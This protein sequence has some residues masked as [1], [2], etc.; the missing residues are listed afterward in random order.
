MSTVTI[1]PL[2]A[3]LIDKSRATTNINSDSVNVFDVATTMSETYGSDPVVSTYPGKWLLFYPPSS[4]SFGDAANE[5]IASAT[6][7]VKLSTEFYATDTSSSVDE[8][9]YYS[10]VRYVELDSN[11]SQYNSVTWNKKPS[12]Q[13]GGTLQ[14]FVTLQ[15]SLASGATE[16][17]TNLNL[18]TGS[19]TSW[20][21]L[22]FLKKEIAYVYTAGPT[23]NSR[24]IINICGTGDNQKFYITVQTEGDLFSL[25]ESS[26]NP[27]EVDPSEANTFAW[28]FQKSPTKNGLVEQ[29]IVTD[30]VFYWESLADGMEHQ[31]PV[32]VDATSITIPADTFPTTG[33]QWHVEARNGDLRTWETED[34]IV[35][36]GDRITKAIL[37]SPTNGV[38]CNEKQPLLLG[39]DTTNA[40][41][42]SPS[43]FGIEWKVAGDDE[44]NTFPSIGLNDVSA[45][46]N[47]Y[48]YAVPENTFPNG[49]ITWRIRAYNQD[50]I[51]GPWS[52]EGYFTTI[53]YP[54]T[55][56]AISPQSNA[57]RDEK[58]PILFEWSA[59][60]FP[61]DFTASKWELQWKTEGSEWANLVTLTQD[62]RSYTAPADTFP[63]DVITWRVRGYNG[64][65]VPGDWSDEASFTTIDPIPSATIIA[66]K[67]GVWID[68]KESC[69]FQWAVTTP[70]AD[71]DTAISELQ[72]KTELEG[73]EWAAFAT[74][75]NGERSYSVPANALPNDNLVWRVRGINQDNVPG[76][77]AEEGHFT[78]ID[79]P[80]TCHDLTPSNSAYC[81]S[82]K[83]IVLTWRTD[84]TASLFTPS[85]FDLQWKAEGEAHYNGLSIVADSDQNDIS[86]KS[87]T[88]SADTLD[89][90]NYVWRVR[91]YNRDEMPS[92]WSEEASFTTAAPLVSVSADSPKNT[93]CSPT[94]PIICEWSVTS[95]G[96]FLWNSDTDHAFEIEYA[97]G[98]DGEWVPLMYIAGSSTRSYPAFN[99]LLSEISSVETLRWRIRAI[100]VDG[101]PGAWS[102][103]SF[104]TVDSETSVTIIGP[105]SNAIASIS[106]PLTISWRTNNSYGNAATGI[107]LQWSTTDSEDS[108]QPL[109]LVDGS[110]TSYTVPADTFSEGAIFWRIR[111]FNQ[112]NVAGPWVTSALT[113]SA[114][115]G[116]VDVVP[117]EIPDDPT[118]IYTGVKT[119]QFPS[120]YFSPG[121]VYWRVRCYDSSNNIG[122][123]S[124]AV[125]FICY[126]IPKV[127]NLQCDGKPFA[128]I[129]WS[130]TGQ[131]SYEIKID[132]QVYYGPFH[133]TDGRF[134]LPE[135]LEDGVHT[136][137][138]QVQNN[139]SLLTP[140]T[141]VEITVQN[142][143]SEPDPHDLSVSG[144]LDAVLYWS[145]ASVR[146]G[147][148]FLVYRDETLIKKFA[149]DVCSYIDR[150]TLGLH[151]YQVIQHMPDGYY[152]RYTHPAVFLS[153]DVTKIALYDGGAWL[154]LLLTSDRYPTNTFKATRVT[155]KTKIM[156][157][158]YP[159]V[160]VSDFEELSAQFEVYWPFSEREKAYQF[161]KFIGKAVI[162]KSRGEQVICGILD[163]YEMPVNSQTVGFTF[164]IEQMSLD[165]DLSIAIRP[166]L[167]NM[168]LTDLDRI[169]FGEMTS[170]TLAAVASNPGATN[171][172]YYEAI[173]EALNELKRIVSE[174]A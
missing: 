16:R 104:T 62:A 10:Q 85:A 174:Q 142:I 60:S 114:S 158:K 65:D 151:L 148:E 145:P 32:A 123:W 51:A 166:S 133:G 127:R 160:E 72:L 36:T 47:A 120:E 76:E 87:Y 83:P 29:P 129:T 168:Y 3:A 101:K 53:D 122:E 159:V 117:G 172:K 24:D 135:P 134:V 131:V 98:S 79:P 173:A 45:D 106:R 15:D 52:E 124:D 93:Y 9:R 153:T 155:E 97:I 50:N 46:G 162:I 14:Y 22:P 167:D 18:C 165:E 107:E 144:E 20:I 84:T 66:P 49:S 64:D 163:G 90:N 21:L 157:S 5:A 140:W 143:P 150:L 59:S 118:D 4:L 26:E 91:A 58:A 109:A 42:H 116:T 119:C 149:S 25:I 63:N 40:L 137:A 33:I 136:I 108:Y 19:S 102:E 77:W 57:F 146:A 156:G 169:R 82:H 30:I 152:N 78:T 35:E 92:D 86:L 8:K 96:K 88:L 28:E 132:D 7:E 128:T 74:L 170:E 115:G 71:Y 70:E 48:T 154:D 110:A 112:D 80:I 17:T 103:A 161:R 95:N 1:G 31:I 69:V 41:F 81:T 125:S 2:K 55:S 126:G 99:R 141:D 6:M 171:P 94:E 27:T 73:A 12:L 43:S 23:T 139:L 75:T 54:I 113:V 147:D 111:A 13:S 56:V 121:Q 89:L 38:Y 67:D 68:E 105:R 100:N 34:S 11:N 130:A 164:T 39:W 138:V 61:S 44:W 37:H